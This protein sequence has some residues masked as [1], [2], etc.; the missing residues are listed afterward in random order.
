MDIENHL[1]H[2]VEAKNQHMTLIQK[3]HSELI[4][5]NGVKFSVDLMA[6]YEEH[7]TS[8]LDTFKEIKQEKLRSNGFR[9]L[10]EYLTL[11]YKQVLSP[12]TDF[13][14]KERVLIQTK[15]FKH[16]TEVVVSMLSDYHDTVREE[17]QLLLICIA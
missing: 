4:E 14:V 15:F 3:L 7:F 5:C 17:S 2:Y 11:F 10:R 6:D 8:F 1:K 16:I 12:I 9:I 13:R